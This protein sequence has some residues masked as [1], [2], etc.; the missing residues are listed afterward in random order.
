MSGHGQQA[1]RRG[2]GQG[3]VEFAL[4][5]P[6]IVLMIFG[7]VDLGR[8]VFTYNTLAQAARQAS[9]TAIVNQD[10]NAVRAVAASS[11]ATLGLGSSNVDVCFKASGSSQQDCSNAGADPCSTLA[12]G[13]LAIVSAHIDFSPLTPIIGSLFSSIPLS[14]TSI[15]PIESVCPSTA[16]PTC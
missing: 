1:S 13:C 10:V 4:V 3:L 7:L 5:L 12:I 9:R 6:I 16:R 14:S 2:S 11:G 15:Q 8:A